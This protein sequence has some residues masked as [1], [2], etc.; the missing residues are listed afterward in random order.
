MADHY[1][2]ADLADLY[3]D[4]N[5]WGASADF[6]RDLAVAMGARSI[7]DL[8]CGTGTVTRGIVAAIGGAGVGVDPAKPMLDVAR[9]KTKREPVEWIEGDARAIRLDRKFDFVLMTGHAFQ[10]MLTD[11]DQAM[12]LATIAAHLTPGGTFG[13]ESRNPMAREWLEWTPEL[14]RRV[15]DTQAYGPVEIWDEAFMRPD[16][17]IIDVVE[18]YRIIGGGRHWRSDFQL[19][20]TPRRD[21]LNR[22][23]SAGLVVDHCFGDWSSAPVSN[24]SREII[25]TGR[26]AAS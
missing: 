17:Q 16:N 8:G 22:I 12:L 20:F 25:I 3:D 13:F 19:R 9:R 21:L 14:S 6:Y 5:G 11:A 23:A 18:R 24:G 10:A 15:V 1:N 4:E 2:Q 7:L 26:R